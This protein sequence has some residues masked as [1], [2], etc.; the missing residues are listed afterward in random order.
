MN[1][2]YQMLLKI[3]QEKFGVTFFNDEKKDFAISDY[4][5]DSIGFI[6]FIIAVEE[7]FGTELPDDFLNYEL[8]NSAYGFI[9]KLDF[10]KETN[11][12]SKLTSI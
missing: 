12:Q 3:L 10:F 2:S 6:T 11:M 7:E 4:I 9:E 8:L 5:Q 1:S